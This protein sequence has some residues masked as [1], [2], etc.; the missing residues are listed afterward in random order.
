MRAST[1]R[2]ALVPALVRRTKHFHIVRTH[3]GCL[4]SPRAGHVLP[5]LVRGE[6]LRGFLC[7]YFVD[8]GGVD[9]K[10]ANHRC[11]FEQML[12][13]SSAP[14][15]TVRAQSVGHPLAYSRS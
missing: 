10:G 12:V 7:G 3:P 6:L 1:C 14:S 4:L 15:R 13:R 9:I 8:G 11:S 5:A 2:V